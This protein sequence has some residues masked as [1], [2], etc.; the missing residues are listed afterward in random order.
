MGTLVFPTCRNPEETGGTSV[1]EKSCG[2]RLHVLN[3][4]VTKRKG[5]D[6]LDEQLAD[7]TIDN[8]FLNA[9]VRAITGPF[10]SEN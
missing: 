4:E 9:G 7:K 1:Y 10:P 3:L 5:I 6:D 2:D 8:L